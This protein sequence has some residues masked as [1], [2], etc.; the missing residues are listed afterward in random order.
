[1]TSTFLRILFASL[2]VFC[3]S[4]VSF[5]GISFGSGAQTA[6]DKQASPALALFD[7]PAS[8]EVFYFLLTDRFADGDPSNNRGG[9]A[10]RPDG[11]DQKEDVIRHGYE[12]AL[13]GFYHGGDFAGIIGKLDYLQGLGVTSIWLSPIFKNRPTQPAEGPLGVSAAYHGYWVSD[14]TTVDPHW[15]Q[16]ADFKRLIEAA[17]QRGMKVFIDAIVNHTA[18]MISYREC[19]SCPYRSKA[20]FPYQG[21]RKGRKL[22]PGFVDG[23][24]SAANF[25]KLKDPDFAYTPFLADPKQRKKPEWLND[26]IYYH[27]RGN[28]TFSGEN[29]EL[30]DFYGLDDLFTEHPRVLSGMIEIY[31]DWIKKYKFDGLRVDTVKHVNIEF[32]QEFV[33]ALRQAAKTAGIPQFFIFGEVFSAEPAV[34]SHYTR[35]GKMDSVLDFSFQAAVKD[36]FA[37]GQEA[38]RLHAAL[39][40]DDLHRVASAPEK[41]MTFISNHDI[42][43]L[44]TF[45]KAHYKEAS[46]AELLKRLTLAQAFLFFARGIP[47]LYYGDEQG[48]LGSGGDTGAREDM[49]A[50]RTPSYQALAPIAAPGAQGKDHFDTQHPLYQAIQ[51]M[52]ALR[53]KYPE[54]SQGEYVPV[55]ELGPDVF[56]FE[57]RV[58]GQ[59]ESQ[60]LLFNLHS[61]ETRALSPAL[62]SRYPRGFTPLWPETKEVK[63]LELPPLSYAL[64]QV[65]RS[66]ASS[67]PSLQF[68]D[69]VDGQP[70]SGLFALE[71]N[72]PDSAEARVSF[73]SRSGAEKTFR[74]LYTDSNPPYRAYID[75]TTLPD[76]TELWIKA[77]VEV[78]GQA[79]KSVEQRVLVDSRP[80]LVRLSYENPH[81]RREAFTISGKGRIALPGPLGKDGAFSF[82]WP[83]DED[84]QLVF[85]GGE[86]SAPAARG[87]D[88]PLRLSYREHVLPHLKKGPGGQA[89]V[90]IYV[91]SRHE[92]SFDKAQPAGDTAALPPLPLADSRGNEAPLGKKDLFLRGGMNTWEP[93]N[94]LRY[95]GRFTYEAEAALSPGLIEF[96]CAD[97]DWQANLNFGAPVSAAGF[98][99]SG[100]SGNLSVQIPEKAGGTYRF[101]LIALPKETFPE[102][103][104]TFMRIAPLKKK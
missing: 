90:T 68:K 18:D 84:E 72:L 59:S 20:E 104:L 103:G 70:K 38:E 99:A 100:G 5:C 77:N 76:G 49:F 69:V 8:A 73:A 40:A 64:V 51:S 86:E 53:K 52:A 19:Q 57:R 88:R 12:P 80:P 71:L 87:Y 62:K 29:S 43:R 32:W 39:A 1:M 94:P 65:K 82:S 55:R 98:T 74:P 61:S 26:P 93:K 25:A 58:F 79:K 6:A 28:S 66:L 27:N 48:L 44:A 31:S 56:A 46:D 45:M 11:P 30:G 16:E 23:D 60:L 9:D 36:V 7:R 33:P 21:K 96:K 101:E 10:N 37:E 47:V 24:R 54:F 97:K 85:F 34:L 89:I 22:N 81:R 35:L 3:P 15:G 91:N 102:G 4:L 17:H 2:L 41:M 78:P 67:L 75:G 13:E 92:L 50:T 63:A 14:F 83:L 95:Q 42:G